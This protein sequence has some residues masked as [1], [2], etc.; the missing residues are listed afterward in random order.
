MLDT[1]R[2][3]VEKGVNST[4]G[5]GSTNEGVVRKLEVGICQ[6]PQRAETEVIRADSDEACKT[7]D[8]SWACVGV[9]LIGKCLRTSLWSPAILTD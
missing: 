8:D 9:L 3:Q 5:R 7:V 4:G 6:A 2:S 1:D